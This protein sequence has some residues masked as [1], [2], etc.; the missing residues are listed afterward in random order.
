[1]LSNRSRCTSHTHTLNDQRTHLTSAV[2]RWYSGQMVQ[3]VALW[4]LR[5]YLLWLQV[6]QAREGTLNSVG[7]WTSRNWNWHPC[8]KLWCCS[9]LDH[10]TT[11]QF[12]GQLS[13][14]EAQI[15]LLLKAVMQ[16]TRGDLTGI[17]KEGNLSY[18]NVLTAVKHHLAVSHRLIS[19]PH[20]EIEFQTDNYKRISC[21]R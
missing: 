13:L 5:V 15:K 9:A 11:I 8:S 20:P 4:K 19:C 17:S 2:V 14:A 21:F 16:V 18:W 6:L 10:W 12:S 1:M 3:V 7:L